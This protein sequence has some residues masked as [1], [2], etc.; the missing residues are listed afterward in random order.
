MKKTIIY[1]SVVAILL[2][3]SFGKAFSQT[4]DDLDGNITISGA[5]ALYPMA[6]KWAEEFKKL[7]LA[8]LKKDLYVDLKV[9]FKD[10]ELSPMSPYSGK[11]AGYGIE[12]GKL[13]VDVHYRIEQRKLTAEN[14][15]V[16]DQFTFGEKVNSPD[17]T[18][19]PVPGTKFAEVPR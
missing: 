2:N 12:K 14:R 9:S 16:L 15:I 3:I 1:V 13:S 4:K 6:V 17:A 5:F 10:I 18:K 11:Y 19:L 8:T 7:D